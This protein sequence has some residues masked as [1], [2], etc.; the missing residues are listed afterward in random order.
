MRLSSAG[1]LPGGLPVE[2][3]GFPPHERT[4]SEFGSQTILFRKKSP[5]PLPNGTWERICRLRDGLGRRVNRA[6][7]DFNNFH[8]DGTATAANAPTPK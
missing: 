4:V 5:R 8:L 2:L 7:R 3:F 6:S 1:F